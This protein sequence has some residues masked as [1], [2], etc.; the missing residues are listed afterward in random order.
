M[1]GCT[2]SV[3]AA[4]NDDWNGAVSR[5]EGENPRMSATCTRTSA[6][7]ANGADGLNTSTA[8]RT[9]NS[10]EL[11]PSTGASSCVSQNVVGLTEAGL[12]GSENSTR[13]W[14]SIAASEP[15]AGRTETATNSAEGTLTTV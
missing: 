4:V 15:S 3:P 11:A 2:A 5:I 8:P 1:S 6:P 13:T 7:G 12:T 10:T 14:A 9:V